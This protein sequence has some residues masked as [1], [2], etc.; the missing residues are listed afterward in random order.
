MRRTP[1]DL[2]GSESPDP[3]TIDDSAWLYAV[4]EQRESADKKLDDIDVVNGLLDEGPDEWS[5]E[6]SVVALAEVWLDFAGDDDVSHAIGVYHDLW[7]CLYGSG[8][9]DGRL[10]AAVLGRAFFVLSA[11]GLGV[12]DLRGLAPLYIELTADVLEVL[13]A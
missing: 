6:P 13:V 1:Y 10:A 12:V 8:N 5:T 3:A 2:C 4:E 9:F 7:G 11:H